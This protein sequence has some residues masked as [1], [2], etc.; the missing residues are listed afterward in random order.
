MESLPN[1]TLRSIIV[2]SA[3]LFPDNPAESYV[4]GEPIHYRE[5]FDSVCEMAT[6]LETRGIG[7]GDRVAI[8][9]ENQ[10]NWAIAYFAITAMGAVAVPI[11][12]DFRQ[13]EIR[14][15]LEHSESKALVVSQKQLRKFSKMEDW[16]APMSVVLDTIQELP[17]DHVSWGDLEALKAAM[18]PS[19][20]TDAHFEPEDASVPGGVDEEDLSCIL[21][22]SGTTGQSKGVML[23]NRNLASNA[24]DGNIVGKATERDRILGILPLAHTFQCTLGMIISTLAG[25]TSYYL[26]KMPTASVLLPAMAKVRPTMMLVVPLVVEKIHRARVLPVVQKNA[27]TRALYAFGP[28]RKLFHKMAARKLMRSFGGCIKF[29]GIGGAAVSPEVERFLSEGGFPYSIGYG[30]T[31][32]SPLVA[33]T[34]AAGTRFRGIGPAIPNVEIRIDNPHPETGEGEVVTRGPNIMK[35]YYKDPERTAQ[36]FTEDGWFR[37]GDLGVFKDGYLYMKGRLKNVII[38]PS[39]ENIYPEEIEAVINE[40]EFVL[41]SLVFECGGKLVA[42]VH[43]NYEELRENLEHLRVSATQAGEQIGQFLQDMREHLNGRLNVFSRIHE[44][45]E[46]EEPFEKTPTQKIKRFLYAQPD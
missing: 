29:F 35:G 43:L 23:T 21:Y 3:R 38:G 44:I 31:E 17:K 14:N 45:I 6:F 18:G 16:T 42:R 5:L 8:V 34:D 9:S 1:L 46:Q 11:L 27:V 39:G 33:G 19:I 2:R 40:E 30:L 15:I 22:T 25:G 13:L 37:T 10:P 26:R 24:V 20:V 36:A 41:E 28:T 32:T 4:D 12:P 7:R